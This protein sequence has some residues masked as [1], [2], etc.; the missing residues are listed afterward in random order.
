MDFTNPLYYSLQCY[1]FNKI[2][3][4]IIYFLL[5][6]HIIKFPYDIIRSICL[7]M[8]AHNYSEYSDMPYILSAADD[9][10]VA[11]L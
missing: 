1:F 7:Y 11:V 10:P 5:I 8:L 3:F 6:Y 2:R 4:I 9:H